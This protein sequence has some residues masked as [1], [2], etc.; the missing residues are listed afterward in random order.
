MVGFSCPPIPKTYGHAPDHAVN[1]PEHTNDTNMS[2]SCLIVGRGRVYLTYNSPL[3]GDASAARAA[4]T[5][6][7]YAITKHNAAL[8]IHHLECPFAI[9][10]LNGRSISTSSALL[11]P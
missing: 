5:S 1:V 4:S 7:R 9:N 2:N 10:D 3:L 8:S 11:R 6:S